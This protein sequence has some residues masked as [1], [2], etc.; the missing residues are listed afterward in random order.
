MKSFTD[1]QYELRS[2]DENDEAQPRLDGLKLNGL[3]LGDLD[4]PTVIVESGTETVHPTPF[5]GDRKGQQGKEGDEENDQ[6]IPL[7]FCD[8]FP[9]RQGNEE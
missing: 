3:L 8:A 1:P 7:A 9:G 4:Q 6:A 5:D 2:G